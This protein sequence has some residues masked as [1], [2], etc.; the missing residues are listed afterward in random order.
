MGGGG[1]VNIVTQTMIQAKGVFSFSNIN[2]V[3]WVILHF[4]VVVC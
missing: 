2:S 1:G 3:F 4:F